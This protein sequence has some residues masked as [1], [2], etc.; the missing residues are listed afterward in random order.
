MSQKV[1]LQ[2]KL[3]D[4]YGYL[5]RGAK[6]KTRYC[7]QCGHKTLRKG[8]IY[9]ESHIKS[10][11]FW[12]CLHNMQPRTYR[13]TPHGRTPCGLILAFD[14][15]H[16]EIDDFGGVLGQIS[17]IHVP[18][19]KQWLLKNDP[20]IHARGMV[21]IYKGPLF[22]VVR[23]RDHRGVGV[24]LYWRAL[25]WDRE[26]DNLFHPARDM[27]D[28]ARSRAAHYVTYK[29]I[30]AARLFAL[31]HRQTLWSPGD[32]LFGEGNCGKR[33]QAQIV[34][35]CESFEVDIPSILLECKA[36]NDRWE[37]EE[38]ELKAAA[39][40]AA[41]SKLSKLGVV[42]Y[43][44]ETRTASIWIQAVR[45]IQA[46]EIEEL[47][48]DKISVQGLPNA[49]RCSLTT[50]E[51][52]AIEELLGVSIN[53]NM[54][55]VCGQQQR[56]NSDMVSDLAAIVHRHIPPPKVARSEGSQ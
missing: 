45:P 35:F 53:V 19:I 18:Q 20:D 44:G 51:A 49:S 54:N 4:V 10:F 30:P 34:E 17:R 28:F 42:S 41:G 37:R 23:C 48:K 39:A 33:M 7:P 13:G 11:T 36:E 3:N 43:C 55:S 14:G 29:G 15:A 21:E 50:R 40:R 26:D 24:K 25:T 12:A 31:G 8:R 22:D 6:R 9:Q 46:M 56:Y 47:L 5:Y 1:P 2:Y 32:T 27:F 16:A 38:R 52:L